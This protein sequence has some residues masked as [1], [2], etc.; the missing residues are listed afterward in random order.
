MIPT[1][2]LTTHSKK[3]VGVCEFGLQFSR[4]T[5]VTADFTSLAVFIYPMI[6]LGDSKRRDEKNGKKMTISISL[7]EDVAGVVEIPCT[8]S[9]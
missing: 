5:F 7:H 4:G 9:R 3:V 2:Y 8:P 6:N 1:P